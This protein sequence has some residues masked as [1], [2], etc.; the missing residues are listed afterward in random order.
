[1]KKAMINACFGLGFIIGIPL[2]AG[3]TIHDFIHT[4]PI[5]QLNSLSQLILLLHTVYTEYL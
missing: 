3:G 4:A 5:L 1:M 2:W